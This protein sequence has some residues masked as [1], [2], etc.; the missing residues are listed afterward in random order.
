MARIDVVRN[1]LTEHPKW[2]P[3]R[4]NRVVIHV[5]IRN[6]G[7]FLRLVGE[8]VMTRDSVESLTID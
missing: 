8:Q 3:H 6:D 4:D 1:W 7:Y 2:L 5:N